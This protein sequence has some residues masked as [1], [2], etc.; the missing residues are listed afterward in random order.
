MNALTEEVWAWHAVPTPRH[1]R[2]S[3]LLLGIVT[4]LCQLGSGIESLASATPVTNL[5]APCNIA[6]RSQEEIGMLLAAP[7]IA[8]PAA[9]TDGRTLPEGIPVSSETAIAIEDVVHTWL[10]C[11]NV[12]QPLRAWA[13]FSDGYLYRLL[14]RQGVPADGASA[15]STPETDANGGADLLEIRD[16]RQLPDGRFGATV[17]IAYPAVPVPKAFF[18]SF[19][20]IDGRLLIDGILGEISF[21]VP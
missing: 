16:Q 13:L 1:P 8:T 14:I 15:A 21:A 20:E 6:P 18:F 9:T 4:I 12:G 5:N 11:Q 7:D 3:T 2:V 19:T 17:V 10:A